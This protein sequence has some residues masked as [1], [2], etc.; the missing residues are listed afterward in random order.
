MDE[1]VECFY[2]G[3]DV[4]IAYTRLS[5]SLKLVCHDCADQ[6]FESSM[7][8]Y[9]PNRISETLKVDNEEVI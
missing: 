2:C 7:D 9:T 5:F 1:I 8:D 6:V 3:Q 4:D